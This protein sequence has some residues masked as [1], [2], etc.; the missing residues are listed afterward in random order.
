MMMMMMCQIVRD[1]LC[2]QYVDTFVYR[3]PAELLEPE[4]SSSPVAQFQAR[5]STI[6]RLEI[7]CAKALTVHRLFPEIRQ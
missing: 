2:P 1:S 5:F 6:C 7:L 3:V 4:C